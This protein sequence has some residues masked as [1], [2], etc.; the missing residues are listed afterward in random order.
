MAQGRAAW[1]LLVIPVAWCLVSAVTLYA[2][3]SPQALIPLAAAGL[4]VA[5]R[6][7]SNR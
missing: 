1:L 4:A 2:M 3:G 5:A 7:G 6:G